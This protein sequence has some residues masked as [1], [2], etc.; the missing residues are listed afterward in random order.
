V[1]VGVAVVP[2]GWMIVN[3]AVDGFT[4]AAKSLRTA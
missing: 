4:N 1:T 3:V 2:S